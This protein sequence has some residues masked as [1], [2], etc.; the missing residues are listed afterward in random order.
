MKYLKKPE[1][2]RQSRMFSRAKRDI[3]NFS[4]DE[5]DNFDDLLLEYV[6]KYH[7][8]EMPKDEQGYHHF[9]SD[10]KETQYLVQRLANIVI[11]IESKVSDLQEEFLDIKNNFIPRVENFG[12]YRVWY[13]Q[14]ERNDDKSCIDITIMKKEH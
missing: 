4:K 7:M 10:L 14:L 6:D 3:S 5:R 1:N 2:F 9:D 12:P 8:I 11:N 13:C